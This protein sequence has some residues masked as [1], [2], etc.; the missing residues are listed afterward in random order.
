MHPLLLVIIV[1]IV[2]CALGVFNEFLRCGKSQND[3]FPTHVWGP[4]LWRLIHIM[5]ANYPLTFDPERAKGY[6]AFFESLKHTLPCKECRAGYTAF[7]TSEGPLKLRPELFAD[8]DSLFKWT[9][10]LHDAVN[11]KLH[12]RGFRQGQNWYP[13]YDALRSGNVF[14]F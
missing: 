7:I 4:G 8:R 13:R 11:A 1:V 6:H 9:T 3:G 12:K 14:F 2:C 10:Q 5:A